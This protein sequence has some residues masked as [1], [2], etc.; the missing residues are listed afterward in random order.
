MSRKKP[1]SAGPTPGRQRR[2]LGTFVI[3]VGVALIVPLIAAYIQRPA[4]FLQVVAEVPLAT[5]G[6]GGNARLDTIRWVV[7]NLG[8]EGLTAFV[9]QADVR[10]PQCSA[11]G[12]QRAYV[13]RI[14]KEAAPE[15][16]VEQ[17]DE[18]T[19]RFHLQEMRTSSVARLGVVIRRSANHR[20][21][22]VDIQNSGANTKLQM[23]RTP[24]WWAWLRTHPVPL[25][26]SV[27]VAL[28][29]FLAFGRRK[30]G[31]KRQARLGR[32]LPPP[33]GGWLNLTAQREALR[34]RHFW[35]H[36]HQRWRPLSG[37]YSRVQGGHRHAVDEERSRRP[38]CLQCAGRK[39]L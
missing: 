24:E 15:P 35:N 14:A 28:I 27:T 6:T 13:A 18:R 21:Y 19:V 22:H 8:S 32:P 31:S 20:C 16:T 10:G 12:I 17:V 11:E 9:L 7:R 37:R 38:V 30:R 23:T 39:A 29:P 36:Q 4:Q 33:N 3:E 2:P 25:V 1:K 5:E 26:I 34:S